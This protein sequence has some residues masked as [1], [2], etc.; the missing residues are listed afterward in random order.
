[1]EKYIFWHD[2]ILNFHST[3]VQQPGLISPMSLPELGELFH[4]N[5]C[6]FAAD[7]DP[8]S[9]HFPFQGPRLH[10]EHVSLKLRCG[11]A[12]SWS[13]DIFRA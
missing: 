9:C 12:Q 2:S 7:S 13:R 10:F 8:H 6:V 5:A 4:S 3:T 11:Q 1:M